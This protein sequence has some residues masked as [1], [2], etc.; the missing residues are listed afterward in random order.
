MKKLLLFVLIVALLLSFSA[1]LAEDSYFS[2]SWVHTE[3]LETGCPSVTFI[4]LTEDHKCFFLIQS[5]REDEAGPGRTYVGTW[6]VEDGYLVAKTGNNT[7]TRLQFNEGY[8]VAFCPDTFSF[9][10][11]TSKMI[12]SIMNELTK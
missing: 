12:D 4:C 6:E 1:A 8:T 11:H 2:G 7:S 9:Y 5:F 10:I 3:M